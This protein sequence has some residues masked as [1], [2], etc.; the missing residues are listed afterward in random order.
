MALSVQLCAGSSTAH[1]TAPN[2]KVTCP[3]PYFRATCEASFFSKRRIHISNWMIAV[4]GVDTMKNT[5]PKNIPA[6]IQPCMSVPFH[7]QADEILLPPWQSRRSCTQRD[8]RHQARNSAEGVQINRS[9]HLICFFH[10]GVLENKCALDTRRMGADC[11]PGDR[12]K[13]VPGAPIVWV[14]YSPQRI[15]LT[16]M[17]HPLAQSTR[18]FTNF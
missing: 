17:N 8:T 9:F 3:S 11:C 12:F 15:A 10:R 2:W 6:P 4:I 5:I 16:N 1:V 18:A 14:L 7:I 13:Q